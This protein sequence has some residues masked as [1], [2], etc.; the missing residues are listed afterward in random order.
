MPP[1]GDGRVDKSVMLNTAEA[2]QKMEA[3]D[4]L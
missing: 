2:S 1:R 4:A 3:I